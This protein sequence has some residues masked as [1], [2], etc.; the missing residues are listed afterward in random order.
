MHRPAATPPPWHSVA[1]L[2]WAIAAAG[3]VQLAPSPVYV[4]LVVGI[5]WVMVEAHAPDGPYRRAFPIL[6]GLGC[7]FGIVRVF[8]AALTTHNGLNILFTIPH[9]T[10]PDALGGFTVGGSI[11]SDVVLQ[12][13]AV[14][15]TVIGVMAVF[16]AVN[17][18]WSHYELVQST[19]RSF[20]EL[21]VV[22]TVALAYIPA[23]IDSMR[24]VREAD[25]ARTGGQPVRRGRILRSIL[26]VLERGMERAVSLAE[27]MDSR[28]FGIR[29][30]DRADRQAAWCAVGALGA[31]GVAFL[32]LVGRQTTLA[33]VCAAVAVLA[34]LA[35]IALGARSTPR[36]HYRRRPLAAA[37]WL[38]MGTAAL[39]PLLL[40]VAD[41]SGASS[42]SWNASP[43]TWPPFDPLVALAFLPLLVPL[44]RLPRTVPGAAP[45]PA[46]QLAAR[47]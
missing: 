34:L 23:T 40:A 42:L 10:M 26:P 27:S 6:V 8:M 38:M 9:A 15:F 7:V 33:L 35:G 19:P 1:W 22:V 13:A 18:I 4:A 32:A 25:R 21:G 17:S 43:L 20:Y 31:L 45:A 41:W 37:D 47:S 29:E 28:G 44:T 39:S 5:A 14:A 2:A 30:A 3:A 36:Q 12:A 24:A 11:E 46:L 16:G